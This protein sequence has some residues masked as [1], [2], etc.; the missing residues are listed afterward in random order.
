MTRREFMLLFGSV[1]AVALW[2]FSRAGAAVPGAK[3]PLALNPIGLGS[4]GTF[5][6]GNDPRGRANAREVIK[7][8]FAE[9]GNLI[10]SSPMYGSS[11]EV[12]GAALTALGKPPALFS[13]EKVWT[14]G[15]GAAQ[16]E[17]TRKRWGL[18]RFDLIQVHNLTDWENKLP[19][20]F[21][22]KARGQLRYAGITTSHGRRHDELEQ[23]M[24]TQPIDFVQ[25]TY[26]LE[27][28]EAEQR[29]LPLAQERGIR[30]IANRPFQ[31]KEL[32]DKV[33]RHPLPGWAKDIDCANWAQVLLKFIVSHP[34]TP[35]AI[36]ATSQVA[37]LKEN[38]GA[39][40][41]RMPDAAFRRRMQDHFVAL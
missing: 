16:I 33:M 21:E 4:W 30:V 32:L 19:L 10:D 37:H 26:N 2:P 13:A 17:D 25:L 20:L 41:G 36:P 8:F 9:G 14:Q 31:R 24:R 5:N 3:A 39:A 38:M 40:R 23:I 29:L 15:D 27:D 7:A 1:T 12:I 18:P 34:S 35:I 11:N 22:M 6:V 28:R